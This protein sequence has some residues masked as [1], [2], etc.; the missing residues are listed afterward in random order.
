MSTLI[1]PIDVPNSHFGRLPRPVD[2]L[3]IISPLVALF[4]PKDGL[5]VLFQEPQ[6]SSN[7]V[8]R[9]ALRWTECRHGSSSGFNLR[10]SS[11][12]NIFSNNILQ[13]R[14]HDERLWSMYQAIPNRTVRAARKTTS[15]SESLLHCTHIVASP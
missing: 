12:A 10:S 9:R 15:S 7:A 4:D 8:Y 1:P 11:V 14:G 3:R 5:D 6:L 13:L 2:E